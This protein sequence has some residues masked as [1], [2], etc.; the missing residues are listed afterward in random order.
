MY[1]LNQSFLQV[2][3]CVKD[4]FN[5]LTIS[6]LGEGRPSSQMSFLDQFLKES[7]V[8]RHTT[9]GRETSVPPQRYSLGKNVFRCEYVYKSIFPL[10]SD[11]LTYSL[12]LHYNIITRITFITCFLSVRPTV[13]DW[14][15]LVLF[16]LFCLS[17][18]FTSQLT[19]HP[20]LLGA[21]VAI[22]M[23]CLFYERID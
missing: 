8:S 23:S 3:N 6:V 15:W 12:M 2:C 18:S 10:H 16:R 9:P 21:L 5:Y 22:I 14:A 17:I 20:W 4:W 7:S 11:W 1:L 19:E 13:L